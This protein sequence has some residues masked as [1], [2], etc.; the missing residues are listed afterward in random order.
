MIQDSLVDRAGDARDASAFR[1]PFEAPDT[2]GSHGHVPFAEAWTARTVPE[3]FEA[4]VEAH[5]D[6]PAIWLEDG[7]LTYV[8]LQRL[9][10]EVA[11]VVAAECGTAPRTIAS[12]LEHEAPVPAAMLG[13]LS[14]GHCYVPLDPAHPRE[15]SEFVLEDAQCELIVT[16]DR[17]RELAQALAGTRRKLVNLDHLTPAPGTAPVRGAVAPD[18]PAYLLYTSGSTGMPKGVVHT[19]RSLLHLVMRHSNAHRVSA[20][21]RIALLFSY[22]FSASVSNALG[23]LLNGAAVVPYDLRERGTARLEEWLRQREVTVLH[24]VPTVFRRIRRWH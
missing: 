13:I 2:A 24:T 18:G 14:A 5:R 6:R 15:R 1:S 4:Q 16:N 10:D 8:Q 23:A 11:Q 21:D 22:N 9:A 3:R 17:N 7:C 20:D 12:L 19:H